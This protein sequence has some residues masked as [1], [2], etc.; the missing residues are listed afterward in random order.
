MD[1]RLSSYA[2]ELPPERIARV[3][4]GARDRSRLMVLDRRSGA[5]EHASFSGLP[6]FLA[7]GDLLVVN[8]TAVL[9]A[10][11]FGRKPTGG[12]VEAL[13][14]APLGE[15]R[16]RALVRGAGRRGT[17]LLFAG[18]RVRAAL[19]GVDE[20]GEATVR[21]DAPDGG[22][23]AMSAA[24]HAPLPPYIRRDEEEARR[25]RRSDRARYQTVFAAHPGSVAAPT[26]GLHFTARLLERLRSAGVETARV[27]LTVGPGTFRPIRGEDLS[28]HALE[29][30]TAAVPP[31]TAAAV[32]AARA[33]GS[34][35]VAV[36]TTVTR[37][38]EAF[39]DT[40][41]RVAAGRRRVDLFIRPG[42]RFRAVDAL[43]TNFHLPRSSLLVL[44]AAFAGRG[45]ILAAYA[46]AVRRG[47][48]FFSFGD[49][50]LI[51]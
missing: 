24:G 21:F 10:R 39:A 29:A 2:Y 7:P 38:L 45:R 31:E 30:E 49:A 12:R 6:R 17:A 28:A 25:R 26:A 43:V 35:V 40:A 50:M 5:T 22:E 27:T 41:G 8:D 32:A 1:D 20:C 16:W 36:G 48:R 13:L 51:R 15:G 18:G 34:R 4:A 33:R 14:L 23:L 37:T 44:A 11:I 3:P 46:E 47:Y 42:H 9:Q 19:E